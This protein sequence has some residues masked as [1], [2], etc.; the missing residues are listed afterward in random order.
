M[1]Q[2]PTN[3]RTA[4]R[5]TAPNGV[6]VE[7]WT[8]EFKASDPDIVRLYSVDGDPQVILVETSDREGTVTLECLLGLHGEPRDVA[9]ALS[10]EVSKSATPAQGEVDFD[11]R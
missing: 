9:G 10:I 3:A 7:P 1:L 8:I 2:I 11:L 4:I 5:V 6:D